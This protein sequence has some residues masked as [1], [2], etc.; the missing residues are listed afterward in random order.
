MLSWSEIESNAVAFQKRWKNNPGDERQDGQTFQRDFMEIFGVDWRAGRHEYQIRDNEGRLNYIDY[1]LPGKILIEMKSKGE[2]LIRAYNQGVHYIKNLNPEDQPELLL[3]CDFDYFEVTNVR[4]KQTFKKF[5][6]SRLKQ[7]VRM[8]GVLAG[9][10]SEVDYETD[11]EVNIDASYMMAKLHDTL[12]EHGYGGKE[13]ELYLVRLLFCL[14]AED[15]GIFEKGAFERYLKNSNEDGSNLSSMLMQ[16]F[17]VLD[18]PEKKRIPAI[19]EQFREFRY[20]DGHVFFDRL[21]SAWFNQKMRETLISC[22]AF[23]WSYISPAIFGSMFQGVMDPEE[24]RELGAH[25]TSEENIMKVIKPLFLDELWD[26]FEAVKTTVAELQAFQGKLGNLVFLDPACG[27]GNFLIIAYRELRLLEFEVMKLIQDNRQLQIV[28]ATTGISK[29]S[30]N[31]FYGVEL[32]EFACE[33]AQLGMILIKHQM[34]QLISNWFGMNTIDFPIRDNPHIVQGNAL[35]IDW[36]DVVPVNEL[37]YIIGNPPFVGAMLTNDSQNEDIKQ[38]M[39]HIKGYGELDYVCGWFY[40]A[41]LIMDQNSNIKASFVAT[42]SISQGQSVAILWRHLVEIDHIRIDFAYRTF[43]W[44]NEA[45]GR[46]AVHCVIIGFSK[47]YSPSN[48]EYM[49]FAEDETLSIVDNIHPYLVNAP[50]IFI[51]SVSKPL[52]GV[53]EMRF[54][55]MPRDGGNLILTDEQREEIITLY[56]QSAEWIRPYI[57]A[58]EFIN[59]THRW[60]LW[61]VGVNPMELRKFPKIAEKIE[62]VRLFR[63]QSKAAATRKFAETPSLFCQIAQPEEGNYILVPRVSSEKRRYIPIGFLDHEVIAS[64]A[65]FMIPDGTFYEFGVLISAAHMS[66][67]RLAAGRLKSDYRYS[68]DLVYNTFPWPETNEAD[69]LRIENS[70]QAIIDARELYVDYTYSALYDDTFMPSELRNAH[71]ANN[72][73]VREAYGAT[74]MTEDECI[75]DLLQRYKELVRENRCRGI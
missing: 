5:K 43:K 10:D 55:S 69:R 40:K 44:M 48:E 23:D 53:S 19:Q 17:D 20:I 70:A 42:N 4:T 52:S 29:V 72:K 16:L 14:F 31:Q 73:A 65:T 8:F 41:S 64:D 24:R 59:R 61:L 45:R 2:S 62:E 63:L 66:W 51:E 32:E 47:I 26:E 11:I 15:T 12:K 36:V 30:I 1:L 56:P 68:K 54:G 9:Y 74:W 22:T 39:G 67:M 38:L 21:P 3:V 25:Y 75:A 7:H 37:T 27:S 35:R 50:N 49:L 57:G 13:L 60:V 33:I 34:D 28:D 46:A 71:T 6:L 18:T 58:R